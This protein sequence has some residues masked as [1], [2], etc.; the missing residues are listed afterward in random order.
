[1]PSQEQPDAV[2]AV[3]ELCRAAETIEHYAPPGF[4]KD[5]TDIQRRLGLME[6]ALMKHDTTDTCRRCG[7]PFTFSAW[8]FSQKG[9]IPPRH[10]FAC[11]EQRRAERA[12][13]G[14][15]KDVAIPPD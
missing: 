4:K 1:M 5:V 10:C 13:A 7:Q 14:V 9:L 2:K 3:M 6:S 8:R 11:R 12:R 15:P